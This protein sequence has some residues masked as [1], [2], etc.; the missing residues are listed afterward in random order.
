MTMIERAAL[1]VEKHAS[2]YNC[3]QSVVLVL[4]DLTDLSEEQLL[5]AAS[6]FAAGMG[7]MEGS[8]GAVVG[9]VLIAGLLGAG[10]SAR[11]IN[12]A[13]IRKA[14]ALTCKTL[15]GRETGVPLLSCADCVKTA[16]FAFGEALEM[17]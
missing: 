11:R 8:C 3:C 10:R 16:V 13:F 14:G 15:K 2:G 5:R 12:E 6:G 1:A 17:E 9:A 7:N 4:A